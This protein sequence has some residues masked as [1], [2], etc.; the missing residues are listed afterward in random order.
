MLKLADFV[1]QRTRRYHYAVADKAC[2][3]GMH[4]AA[5]NQAHNRLRTIDNERMPGVVPALKTHHCRDVVREPVD[6]L[7]LAFIAPLGTD[8]Y[9]ILWHAG[10]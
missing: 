4:D 6:D 8:D 7:A 10:S 5:G 2:H 1:E 3:P 9:D